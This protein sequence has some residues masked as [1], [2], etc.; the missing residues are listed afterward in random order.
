MCASSVVR[1]ALVGCGR[2]AHVHAG[3][4]RQIPGVVLVG[5]CD[6]AAAAREEFT[7]RWG[8][9]TC[10][11]LRELQGAVEPQVVHVLT[12]PA[13]HCPL[14][15]ELMRA[16]IDVL[17]E[18]PM[19]TTVADAEAM[20]AVALET[21]RVLT[22]DHNRW[23]DPVMVTA[24]QLLDSGQLGTLVGVDV[25]AGFGEGDGASQPWKQEL[26]GGPIYDTAPHPAYLAY[27]FL[28]LPQ[29]VHSVVRR[30]ATGTVVELRSIIEGKDA[31]GTLSMSPRARPFANT[32]TLYGSL[33]TVVINLNNMTLVRR[34]SPQLPKLVAKVFP[35]LDE[36]RQLLV[37]TVANTWEYLLGRQ[38]F[39]PGI[40]GHL[41]AFYHAY[42]HGLPPPV[43]PEDG[44]AVVQLL[45]SLLPPGQSTQMA[46]EEVAA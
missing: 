23:F 20:I 11:S 16:G 8:V 29:R 9:P 18:K 17:V 24:R 43:R 31:V 6:T 19:A 14:A 38:R 42:R 37:A 46:A 44:R 5:A 10:A 27:G 36:A 33:E 3:Y 21:G 25:Y 4:L 41:R 40:G 12:P 1:V 34:R 22:V 13:T 7:R 39:Y 2:I 28:G 15:I 30:D 26:P 35:N 32:V 45:E